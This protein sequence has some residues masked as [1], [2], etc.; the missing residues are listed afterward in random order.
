M[1]ST[2]IAAMLGGGAAA[3]GDYQSIQT[4]TLSSSSA[5][6]T[7]S[8]IPATYTHLQLRVLARSDY[9]SAAS[10]AMRMQING[11]TATSYYTNHLI[12]GDGASALT[13]N[14]VNSVAGLNINRLPAA[15]TASSIFGVLVIDILDYANTNKNKTLR[16]LGGWDA[17]GAGRINFNSGL[18]TSTAAI[19]SIDIKLSTG[20]NYIAYSSFALYGIK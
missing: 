3:V 7:F 19:S 18:F 4:Y 14:D 15:T 11:Q 13:D 17:N 5:T 10:E 6:I 20:S 12:Y 8:S 9:A 1:I 16:T 2:Q